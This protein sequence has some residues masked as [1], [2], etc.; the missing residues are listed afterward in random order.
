MHGQQFDAQRD[1]EGRANGI[2]AYPVIAHIPNY[3]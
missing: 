3:W 1:A 2:L